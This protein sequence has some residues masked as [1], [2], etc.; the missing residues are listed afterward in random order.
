MELAA[1][2]LA[3]I[4]TSLQMLLEQPG[5]FF[6]DAFGYIRVPSALHLSDPFGTIYAFS[7]FC[8]QVLTDIWR[9]APVTV[10]GRGNRF[11]KG[12]GRLHSGHSGMEITGGRALWTTETQRTVISRAINPSPHLSVDPREWQEDC[13][14]KSWWNETGS[15][16]GEQVCIY[17]RR[18]LELI[19]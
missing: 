12:G 8:K 5:H 19:R 9:S 17:F 7:T 2:L 18:L 11:A 13:E 14:G 16:L 15:G 3:A 1:P 4:K 10:G 6:P